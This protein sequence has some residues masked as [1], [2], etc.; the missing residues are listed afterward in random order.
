M[1]I[2]LVCPQFPDS[3]WSYK[4]AMKFISKKSA[5]NLSDLRAFIK[6]VFILGCLN[7]GRREYW[8]LLIWT[9]FN[10]PGHFADA[11][12]STVYGYHYQ[13]VYGLKNKH[14]TSSKIY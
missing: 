6:A 3:F 8:K 10:R 5:I 12:A 7:R 9:L 2:L 1:K 4:H 14:G 13:T 11:I